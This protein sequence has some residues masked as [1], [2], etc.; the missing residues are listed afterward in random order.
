MKFET[1]KVRLDPSPIEERQMNS[2]VGGARFAYNHMLGLING[3]VV[4]ELSHYSLR[5]YWNTIK[6][7]VAPWWA[8][9]SK[10][11]YSNS[12][13][14][15]ATAYKNF[16]NSRKGKRRGKKVG[17]PKFK[18]RRGSKQSF[19]YASGTMEAVGTSLKLPRVGLVHTFEK[20]LE[21]K[22][23]DRTMT[24]ITV[25]NENGKWYASI[26]VR[27]VK[28]EPP[29]PKEGE[30]SVGLDFGVK[31]LITSSDG[32][33]FKNPKALYKLDRRLRK[34]QRRRS[35][36]ARGSNRYE[37]ARK[38]EAR[39]HNKIAN[40]RSD[41][42]NKASKWIADNYDRVSIEDLNVQGMNKLRTL[43]RAV[44]DAAFGELRRMLGY[45][46][47]WSGTQLT[48]VDRWYPSSK[49]CSVC[50]V[51]KTKLLLSEREYVCLDCGTVIDRDLNA[52]RNIDLA[53]SAPESINV[54]G[55]WASVVDRVFDSTVSRVLKR[56]PSCDILIT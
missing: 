45:K 44:N 25:S 16:F 35:K 5:K 40:I 41:Y 37:K 39:L 22:I 2:H 31:T 32:I 17:R 21:N 23:G 26:L 47:A 55:A 29:T 43:T 50:G 52:A 33:E 42:A 13:A 36:R 49:T 48:V 14:N 6:D 1:I 30:S 9:N 20:N 10:E 3:G 56:E 7:E 34:T 8:E 24:R 28:A 19:T 27:D 12:L 11:V 15:L 51:V 38:A 53:G 46:C 54:R 18:S 4:T